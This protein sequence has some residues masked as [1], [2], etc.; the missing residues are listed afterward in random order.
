[1]G[2]FEIAPPGRR[3]PQPKKIKVRFGSPMPALAKD[4]T[5]EQLRD[6]TDELMVRICV[7]SE[8][9]YSG[10]DAVGRG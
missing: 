9:E 10:V 6:W 8:Q 5:A 2:T 7:L 1:V 4:P 3:V